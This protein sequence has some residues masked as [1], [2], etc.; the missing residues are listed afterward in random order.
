MKSLEELAKIR[1]KVK[2]EI[3]MRSDV[4]DKDIRVVIGMATCGIA[5]GA[6]DTMHAFMDEISK[7]NLSNV[8]L[9]QTGC[10]GLCK[11]EP[12]V[13]VFVPGQEKVTYIKV[14]SDKA[15][16]IVS[17]HIVNGNAV[18]EYLIKE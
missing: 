5:A 4:N 18:K 8:K 17:D 13:E 1:D 9:V 2:T 10:V 15:A 16:K 12:I 7:R 11:F 6:R 3:N 14:T